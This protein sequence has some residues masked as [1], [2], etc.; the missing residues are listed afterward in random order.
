MP[1]VCHFP[2][3]NLQLT[4]IESG[5]GG[6]LSHATENL[7]KSARVRTIITML[8]KDNYPYLILS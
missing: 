4:L 1:K 2:S 5:G 7:M 6:K 8:L 3:Y